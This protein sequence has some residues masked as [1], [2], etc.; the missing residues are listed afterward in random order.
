MAADIDSYLELAKWIEE[1]GKKFEDPADTTPMMEKVE[2]FIKD[3]SQKLD[4]LSYKTSISFNSFLTVINEN[5]Q[6]KVLLNLAMEQEKF[7]ML[8]GLD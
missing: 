6:E 5:G 1:R 8:K 7:K 4:N 3:L 2:N